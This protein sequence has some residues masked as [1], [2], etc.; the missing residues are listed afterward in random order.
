MLMI[1]KVGQGDHNVC[2]DVQGCVG[3]IYQCKEM[4]FYNFQLS[5]KQ[6]MEQSN[7]VIVE[8]SK[9]LKKYSK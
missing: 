2:K 5:W 4:I 3:R 1:F 6:A 7:T 9:N 8:Q